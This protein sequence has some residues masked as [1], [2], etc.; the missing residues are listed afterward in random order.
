MEGK[1]S[2]FGT[3]NHT[4]IVEQEIAVEALKYSLWAMP[5]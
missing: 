2:R 4:E 3:S 1:I 5:I